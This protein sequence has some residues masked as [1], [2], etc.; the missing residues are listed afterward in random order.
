MIAVQQTI[1]KRKNTMNAKLSI[2]TYLPAWVTGSLVSLMLLIA[3]TSLDAQKKT[4]APA[5]S[6]TTDSAGVVRPTLP[7]KP[8]VYTVPEAPVV[9]GGDWL[10]DA[11]IY[12]VPEFDIYL[13]H[14]DIDLS[15]FELMAP[16]PLEYLQLDELMLQQNELLQRYDL[17]QMQDDAREM[18]RESM[19]LAREQAQVAR[20]TVRAYSSTGIAIQRSKAAEDYQAAY[21]LV[22]EENWGT[23]QTSLTAYLA[24]Y[25]ESRNRYMDDASFWNIYV[26]EKTGLNAE[27]VF[28]AYDSFITTYSNSKWEDDAKANL[29][30]IGRKLM[31][32]NRK[33]R[34]KYGP[35]VEKYKKDADMEVALAAIYSLQRSGGSTATATIARL[36]DPKADE[37]FR[38]KIVQTLGNSKEESV[39]VKLGEIIKVDPSRKVKEAALVGLSKFK[40]NDALNIIRDVAKNSDEVDIRRYAISRLGRVRFRDQVPLV[41]PILLDIAQ[42][43]PHMKVRTAAVSALGRIEDPRAQEALLQ[44][45]T[46]R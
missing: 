41:I 46:N 5:P 11:M 30:T 12:S 45:L 6:R 16:E 25:S 24:N 36:Y 8:T 35:I 39:V 21:Q 2:K 17:L 7:V 4:K 13:P 43:D 3:A 44:L 38:I 31:A 27:K 10:D 22:L 32:K 9:I 42:N 20:E 34:D 40:G 14:L 23:A 37:R 15:E 28:E 26:S 19:E 33:N 18:A 29:I 1:M